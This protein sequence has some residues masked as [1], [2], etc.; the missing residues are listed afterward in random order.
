MGD[1]LNAFNFLEIQNAKRADR[2]QDLLQDMQGRAEYLRNA[3]G[4][5]PISW[6]EF[7]REVPKP[8]PAYGRNIL[9]GAGIG[10]ALLGGVALV[11]SAPV[12]GLLASGAVVGGLL[13]GYHETQNDSRAAQLE[14]YNNY[15]D[16]FET[17]HGSG[18]SAARSPSSVMTMHSAQPAVYTGHQLDKKWLKER[19]SF[20]DKISKSTDCGCEHGR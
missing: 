3:T 6:Y 2:N 20:A 5:A 7:Q 13:G 8:E 10:G 9:M 19:N 4:E 18:I 17:S 11:F 14:A 12:L 15:L 1:I 16:H